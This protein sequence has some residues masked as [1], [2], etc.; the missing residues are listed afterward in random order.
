VGLAP[1]SVDHDHE[2]VTERPD[3]HTVQE[4]V[5]GKTIHLDELRRQVSKHADALRKNMAASGGAGTMHGVSMEALNKLGLQQQPGIKTPSLERPGAQAG[6]A[7]GSGSAGEA[8]QG[9]GGAGQGGQGGIKDGP[10]QGGQGGI[11][12]GRKEPVVESQTR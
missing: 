12:D 3:A 9:S 10:G 5:H 11:K 6:P 2:D 8:T 1:D 4:D 7:D